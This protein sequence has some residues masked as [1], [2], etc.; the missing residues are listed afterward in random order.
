MSLSTRQVAQQT[1]RD[2]VKTQREQKAKLMR[3]SKSHQDEVRQAFHQVAAHQRSTVIENDAERAEYY[4]KFR[5]Y[6]LETATQSATTSLEKQKLI[7]DA[8][9]DVSSSFLHPLIIAKDYP[10]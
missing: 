6:V 7:A 8:Q 5:D 1:V 9:T 10:S 2:F 4:S 3:E